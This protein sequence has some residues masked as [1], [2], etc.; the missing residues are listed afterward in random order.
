MKVIDFTGGS[1]RLFCISL[2]RIEKEGVTGMRVESGGSY[3]R[4][5]KKWFRPRASGYGQAATNFPDEIVQYRH[6]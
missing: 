6:L 1:S 4:V 3:S 2:K 5:T